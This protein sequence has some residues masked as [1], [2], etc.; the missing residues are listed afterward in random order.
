[1]ANHPVSFMKTFC[2]HLL[3]YFYIASGYNN[4]LLLPQRYRHQLEQF[5]KDFNVEQIKT[6]WK[7]KDIYM[8]IL[9]Y[10]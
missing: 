6:L 8:S 4:R 5:T 9:W 7:M 3:D 1:M 10:I 2:L